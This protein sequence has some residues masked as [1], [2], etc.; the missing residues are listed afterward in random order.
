MHNDMLR[1]K[2][3]LNAWQI[4]TN[5]IDRCEYADRVPAR[6]DGTVKNS[7]ISEGCI[8]NGRVIN[9]VLSPG[10]RVEAKALVKNSIVLHDCVINKGVQMDR[11]ICD[12]DVIVNEHARVGTFGHDIPSTEQGDLL[13]SGVTLIG[14]SIIIPPGAAIGSNTAIFSTA[15]VEKLKIDPG[16]TL[17]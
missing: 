10:V 8:I 15:R 11:T 9:S 12:K 6:I 7:F 4:R 16:S 1:R 3:D 17:R 2:Y 14:K 5:L 13:S